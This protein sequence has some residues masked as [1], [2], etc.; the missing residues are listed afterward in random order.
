MKWLLQAAVEPRQP[1][2]RFIAQVVPPTALGPQTPMT[3][4][5]GDGW[6]LATN[7]L[8]F[9]VYVQLLA[10]GS[11]DRCLLLPPSQGSQVTSLACAPEVSS[12]HFPSCILKLLPLGLESPH[13]PL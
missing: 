5:R 10:L 6:Q 8:P 2:P 12:S 13:S 1:D 11:P 3:S 4:Q 9:A 7:S